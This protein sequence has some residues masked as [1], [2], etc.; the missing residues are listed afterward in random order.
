MLPGEGGGGGRPQ[1]SMASWPQKAV[2][3]GM[4][5]ALV[6]KAHFCLKEVGCHFYFLDCLFLILPLTKHHPYPMQIGWSLQGPVQ[7]L[8]GREQVPAPAPRPGTTDAQCT[9]V[10]PLWQ[11]F[12]AEVSG[13]LQGPLGRVWTLIE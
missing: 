1:V 13:G 10:R 3:Q 2:R 9:S 12:I 5:P 8:P 7:S 4:G 11:V 6:L